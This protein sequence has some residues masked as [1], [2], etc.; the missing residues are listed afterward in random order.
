MAVALRNFGGHVWKALVVCAAVVSSGALWVRHR[1]LVQ[2]KTP[3]QERAEQKK[4]KK[5]IRRRL[6]GLE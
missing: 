6:R 5:E 1:F 3:A 4:R 2:P